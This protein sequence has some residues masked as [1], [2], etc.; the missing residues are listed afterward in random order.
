MVCDDDET[1]RDVSGGRT[2]SSEVEAEKGWDGMKQ[3]KSL[4]CFGCYLFVCSNESGRRMMEG[5]MD[6]WMSRAYE[7]EG[8]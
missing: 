6:G 8:C 1:W 3:V 2:K 7:T 4:G 5:R